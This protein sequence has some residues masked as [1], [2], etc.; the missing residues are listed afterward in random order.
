VLVPRRPAG[1]GYTIVPAPGI[2]DAL[3]ALGRGRPLPRLA[4]RD[5]RE[6]DATGLRGVGVYGTGLSAFVA[7][8]VPGDVGSRAADAITK[9]GGTT[10][11]PPRGEITSL[12]IAPLSVAVARSSYTQR[13]FVLAGLTNT[14]VLL[15]AARTLA[16]LPWSER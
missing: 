14:D 5:L 16:L 11:N 15:T 2:A 8:P 13:W 3:N 10:E 7:V 12:S 6:A 4:G 1:S 9:A